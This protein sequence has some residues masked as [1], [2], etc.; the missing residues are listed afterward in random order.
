MNIRLNFIYL[1]TKEYLLTLIVLIAFQLSM[2]G[3]S[4]Q[5][6]SL[7]IEQFISTELCSDHVNRDALE[8][9]FD[10][11]RTVDFLFKHSF[12]TC[13]TD[14]EL[15]LPIAIFLINN[16]HNFTFD[17]LYKRFSSNLDRNFLIYAIFQKKLENFYCEMTSGFDLERLYDLDIEDRGNITYLIDYIEQ[18]EKE[19]NCN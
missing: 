5:E 18:L 1:K 11:P 9:N 19:H 6:D 12:Y 17:Q 3:Q 13:V 10:N 2:I 7:N 15:V 8:V 14:Y 16:N 4:F